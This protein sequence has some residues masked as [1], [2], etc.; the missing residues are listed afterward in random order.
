M[1]SGAVLL[2][3][4]VAFWHWIAGLL[5]VLLIQIVTNVTLGW[6]KVSIAMKPLQV[7]E[8]CFL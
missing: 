8:L 2:L 6:A 7:F 4:V 3:F 5:C 1:V